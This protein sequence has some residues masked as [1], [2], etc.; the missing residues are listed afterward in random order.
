MR[1]AGAKAAFR[2]DPND[3]TAALYEAV[4]DEYAA[5]DEVSPST[6]ARMKSDIESY[7]MAAAAIA[8]AAQRRHAIGAAW[9]A[10]RER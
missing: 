10:S 1:F 3:A 6:I 2:R 4:T 9:L 8:A 5:R 7:R